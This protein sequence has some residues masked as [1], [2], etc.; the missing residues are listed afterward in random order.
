ME[1]Y[2]ECYNRVLYYSLEYVRKNPQ[3][4]WQVLNQSY[5]EYMELD[6][7]FLRE[8]AN[9]LY[10]DFQG[11]LGLIGMYENDEDFINVFFYV[12]SFVLNA[13]RDKRAYNMMV[14]YVFG[15][16]I[17]TKEQKFFLY[18]RFVQYTFLNPQL[19]DKATFDMK[20][21]IYDQIFDSYYEELKGECY[22]IPKEERN[23]EF[24]LVLISQII[25]LTHGPTKTLL[26]RCYILEQKLNKKIYIINT[27]EFATPYGAVPMFNAVA[28]SYVDEY[29][30]VDGI[31]FMDRNFAM[32]QCPREMPQVN[33]IR[34]ILNVIKTEKPYFILTI[35]GNSIVSDLCSKI[36]STLSLATVFSGRTVTKGT[37]QVIGREKNQSDIDW[38]K[39]NHLP[40]DHILESLFTFT[41]NEQKNTYTRGELGL[42]EEG[43]IAVMVGG[44][45]DEEV[46][47]QCENML[48]RLAEQGVYIAILGVFKRVKELCEKSVA[49]SE[50]VIDLGFRSDVLAIDEC[51]DLYINPKRVGGGTSVAEALYKGLP[52]VTFDFGDVGVTAGADF[53]V[54]DYEDMY[55]TIIKYSKDKEF[56]EEMSKKARERGLRLVDSEGEFLKVIEKM[57][58]SPRF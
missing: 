54:E 7:D 52:A 17:L 15:D 56:Y 31:T 48:I 4:S 46:D 1:T 3:V 43:F 2:R 26:D 6:K 21:K 39:K 13:T 8:N 27:A 51:C 32:F 53:H 28:G 10:Q 44:R 24:V 57:E 34:D 35:G 58:K 40:D 42:P 12:A 30:N 38:L 23:K 11:I 45:L 22:A 18:Y 9:R 5:Q 33:I 16:R 49:F 20:E 47:Q 37:F 55:N 14:E 36:V 19:E 25:D 29:S 50:R 41:F